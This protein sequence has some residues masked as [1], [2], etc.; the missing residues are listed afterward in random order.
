MTFDELWEL[1]G[2]EAKAAAKSIEDGIVKHLYKAVAEQYVISIGGSPTGEEFDRYAMGM[3]PMRE[4]LIFEQV[5]TLEEG[6]TID[7]F[8][9]L[10]RRRQTMAE[11]PRFLY[12]VEFS[13]EATQRV[14]DASWQAACDSL[15]DDVPATVLGLYRVAGMQKM[16]AIVD[17]RVAEDLNRLCRLPALRDASVETVWLMRDYLSFAEDVERHYR[18]DET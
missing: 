7:V 11:D 5:L 15:R 9:Y 8:D 13:R 2:K 14:M 16:Q 6:F 12:F 18:F 10:S 17:V 4:H 1:E 3:L